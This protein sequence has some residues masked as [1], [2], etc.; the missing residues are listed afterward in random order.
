MNLQ[1]ANKEA[2]MSSLE[3][4]KLVKSRHNN[5]KRTME[6]LSKNGLIIYTQTDNSATPLE[7]KSIGE[8]FGSKPT[9][10]YHVNKR[11]SYVVVAQLSPEFTA[12]LVDRW[13]ALEDEINHL[14]YGHGVAAAMIEYQ[15]QVIKYKWDASLKGKSL[16]ECKPIKK[17]LTKWGDEL[18]AWVQSSLL[19][20]VDNEFIGERN[21]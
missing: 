6:R 2:T 13:Q 4:S 12:N 8:G 5:V 19:D 17:S 11:D 7:H 1:A 15:A 3:I 21:E 10:V 16:A 14:K 9:K 20:S 18:N